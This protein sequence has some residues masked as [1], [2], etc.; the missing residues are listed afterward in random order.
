MHERAPRSGGG[1]G[2]RPHPRAAPTHLRR[3]L[4]PPL[5]PVPPTAARTGARCPISQSLHPG[6][7][8]EL[9]LELEGAGE[10]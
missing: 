9:S 5:P 10:A 6:I 2:A 4:P 1:A 3:A 8:Y 7:R